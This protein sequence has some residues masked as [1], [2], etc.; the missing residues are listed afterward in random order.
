[1][2]EEVTSASYSENDI[3]N[4][5]KNGILF[6]E[7]PVNHVRGSGLLLPFLVL[8]LSL[9]QGRLL[10]CHFGCSCVFVSLCNRILK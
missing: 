6:L 4:S 7:D 8:I 10:A 3:S 5:I 9:K 1:M 2:Y